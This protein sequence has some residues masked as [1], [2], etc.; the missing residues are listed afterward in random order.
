[1][2]DILNEDLPSALKDKVTWIAN[3]PFEST[4]FGAQIDAQARESLIALNKA[5]AAK[6]ETPISEKNFIKS[7]SY[8]GYEKEIEEFKRKQETKMCQSIC[9]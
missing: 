3:A 6:G 4:Q 7:F 8:G 2:V 9:F 5:R 1:M